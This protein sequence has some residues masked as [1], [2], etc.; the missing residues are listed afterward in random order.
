MRPHCHEPNLLHGWVFLQNQVWVD[1]WGNE[2]EIELMPL[3]YVANVI[4]FCELRAGRIRL[5]V[6]AEAA[7]RLFDAVTLGDDGFTDANLA[8]F[9]DAV[10]REP[11]DLFA[12][13]TAVEWLHTTPLLG[14]LSQRLE[15]SRS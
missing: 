12:H 1:Y 2:H 15:G 10:G 13:E 4:A 8:A 7:Q 9:A 11:N 6:L 3:D 5:I 14:A